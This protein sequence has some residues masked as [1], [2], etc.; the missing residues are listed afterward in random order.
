MK[1]ILQYF[2]MIGISILGI[3]GILQL[4]KSLEA[5]ASV[6]GVWSV[7]W[8]DLAQATA[9][10]PSIAFGAESPELTISQSGRELLITFQDSNRT[11]F[12]GR[13]QGLTIDAG[14]KQDPDLHFEATI[15]RQA[16][17]DRLQ[18]RLASSQCGIAISLT[19]LRQ[20]H[21]PSLTGEH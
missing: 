9:A 13:L 14:A 5:P 7:Q 11:A 20:G 1:V 19:G 10:C 16:E 21:L 2:M 8:P 12:S 3:L 15:D 17:P 4:G 6:G 18:G